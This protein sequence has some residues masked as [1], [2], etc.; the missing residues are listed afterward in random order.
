MAKTKNF[1]KKP[2]L[3]LSLC[4][5]VAFAA[6][7]IIMAVVPYA[8]T[9]YRAEEIT[10]VGSYKRTTKYEYVFKKDTIK[11]TIR[12]YDENNEPTSDEPTTSEDEYYIEDGKVY[13]K[14]G[15]EVGTIDAYTFTPKLGK[16]AKNNFARVYRVISIV[17]L[18]LGGIG[19]VLY[20]VLNNKNGKAKASKKSS[21]KK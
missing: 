19:L 10:Q 14:G 2:L 20:I 18:S 21:K 13:S 6:A 9:K 15:L 17:G 7:L 8:A 11:T 5:I 12:T 4:F 16:E 1:C 3:L